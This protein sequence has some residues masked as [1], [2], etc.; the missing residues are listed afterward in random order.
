M[1]KIVVTPEVKINLNKYD[2][3]APVIAASLTNAIYS[4]LAAK[5]SEETKDEISSRVI[6]L[7]SELTGT[8]SRVLAED[9]QKGN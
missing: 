2:F 1:E 6:R 4:A 3:M 7:W 5:K 9:S 8:I